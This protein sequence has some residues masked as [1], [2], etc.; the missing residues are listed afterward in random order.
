[1]KTTTYSTADRLGA[2]VVAAMLT[3]GMA[4]LSYAAG[5]SEPLH[6]TNPMKEAMYSLLE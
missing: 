1:M 5:T 6:G 2:F 4:T 3:G